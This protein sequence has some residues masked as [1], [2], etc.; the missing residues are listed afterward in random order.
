MRRWHLNEFGLDHLTLDD[1]PAPEPGPG[2]VRIR[3]HATS[4][5]YRDLLMVAGHYDPRVP[6]PL[7]PCSDGAGVI[8]AVGA[9]VPDRVG[10]RVVAAFAP[11]WLDGPQDAAYLH[12]TLGGPS[13]GALA[14]HL[15]VRHEA[16]IPFPDH[17]SF[18]QASTLPCAGVTA[19]HALDACGIT[20]GSGLLTLGTGGVSIWAL[21]LAVA[22]GARVLVTSSSE[23]KA[24]R[25]RE[26]GAVAT[27]DYNRDPKWGRTAAKLLER[28]DGVIELGGV[29]TL[30]QSLR[31]CRAG[32]TVALIGVLAGD[33]APVS[34][35]R[36]LM[37]G[38]RIQ[39]IMVGSVAH[40]KALCAEVRRHRIEPVVDRVFPFDQ[41]PQAFRHLEC[42]QH[43][44]KVVI[45]GPDA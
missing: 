5:N 10:E 25:A 23:G 36:A 44:G 45:A 35:T 31:A 22:R 30:T 2:Q 38:I 43:L 37:Y 6:R 41:A 42:G 8:D 7:V 19:F 3:I 39:G 4:L 28:V 15:V 17:L 9:G 13:P 18:A 32:G 29:G 1:T 16:A 12:T 26:L 11:D 33:S 20:E 40:L 14:S 27:L 24:A 21:Q 34:L